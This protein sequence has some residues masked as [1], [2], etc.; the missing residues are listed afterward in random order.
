MRRNGSL[1][2]YLV[3]LLVV[4]VA[5]AVYISRPPHTDPGVERLDARKAL[6]HEGEQ[7]VLWVPTGKSYAKYRFF[8]NEN[9]LEARGFLFKKEADVT[10]GCGEIRIQLFYVV[11]ACREGDGLIMEWPFLV[12]WAD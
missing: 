9:T 6:V 10:D 3:V 2:F 4:V 7:L 5:S 11:S 8:F 1:L 12:R